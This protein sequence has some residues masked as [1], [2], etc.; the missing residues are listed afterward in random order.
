MLYSVIGFAWV[1]LFW[2]FFCLL[3][4]IKDIVDYVDCKTEAC[5]KTRL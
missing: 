4:R 3:E 2:G 5:L 1:W